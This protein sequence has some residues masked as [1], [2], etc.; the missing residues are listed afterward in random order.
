MI[1][2]FESSLKMNVE[3]RR[4]YVSTKTKLEAIK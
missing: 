3:N 2:V 1:S 4:K